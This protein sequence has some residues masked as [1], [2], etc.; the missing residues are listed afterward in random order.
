MEGGSFQNSVPTFVDKSR[1]LEVKPLRSLAPVFQPPP[2]A[3]P[4]ACSPPFTSFPQGFP[5]FNQGSE[6]PSNLNQQQTPMGAEPIFAPAPIQSFRSPGTSDGGSVRSTTNKFK[7]KSKRG[8][9]PGSILSTTNKL[10]RKSKRGRKPTGGEGSS[11]GS[12]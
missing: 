12:R 10:K 8:R 7:K 2:N 11:K 3:P 1:V 4:F 5:P 9:K 6:D